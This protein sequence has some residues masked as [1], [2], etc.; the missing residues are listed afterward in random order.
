MK[1]Q[2]L[3]ETCFFLAFIFIHS[4]LA[5]QNDVL[6]GWYLVNLNYHF[7]QKFALYS[8]V[9]V[10]SQH[11]ADDFYYRELKGGL[12]YKFPG[13]QSVLLGFGNYKTYT[14]PG[15]FKEPVEVNENRIWEQFIMSHS[16][17]RVKIEHR[18]RIEQRW[19]NGDFFNRFRYRLATATP[20]NH[21]TIIDNTVYISVF[22]EL[23][24]TNKAPYFIRNRIFFG[25]GYQFSKL[26]TIQTGFLRQ[27]DYRTSDGG[28]GK[29]FLQLSVLFNA[30]KSKRKVHS[31][32]AD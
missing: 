4:A 23:F 8:E 31:G 26:L 13:K 6:G 29:N 24:F 18:Y 12:S 30:G 19:L 9:Q 14:Y 1:Q 22:D 17:S 20:I 10:R 25:P 15:N 2:H 16:I 3:Y 28:S 27:F 21:S 5:A 32:D 11:V 7:N